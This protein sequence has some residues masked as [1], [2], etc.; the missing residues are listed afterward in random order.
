MIDDPDRNTGKLLTNCTL[1]PRNCDVDRRTGNH[2]YCRNGSEFSI[3]SIC[4]HRGE[5]PVI[6]GKHG[7]CNI[8]FTNC[9]LQ[10]I[11]CQNHQ[12]SNNRVSHSSCFMEPEAVINR[13]ISML[14]SG[15][16]R[17]GFVSPGHVIPQMLH[18]INVVEE[19]GYNPVWVYNSNG[20][21]K[22]ETL[23]MLEG[24]ID[25]Y[26]PDMKY[27]DARLGKAFSGASDY[28][29]IAM[30]ALRE[31]FRQ[32][33]AT[34]RLDEEGE[35]ES[36][37]IVRH[38]VLPGHVNN[39]VEVVRFLAGELS[40]RVHLSLMSQYYPARHFPDYPEL[41]R[42]ITENEYQMVVNEVERLGM[43]RGWIQDYESSH[44]YRPDFDLDHPFE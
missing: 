36:G 31:M 10:C 15:I 33:G 5:E 26:L 44:F 9:N 21:D 12:I 25:V 38:L 16:N 32:K 7:I 1:C 29:E 37:M 6:S 13:V 30:M 34:L 17:V 22:V 2:G 11:F 19:R 24:I 35:A 3:S 27:M 43:H 8:F 20:Y 28:P 23:R 18:I 14:D 4:I 39:S 40:P 41:N 42:Y